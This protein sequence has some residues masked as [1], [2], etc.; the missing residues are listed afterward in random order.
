M[1]DDLRRRYLNDPIFHNMV[2][3][4]RGA[5]RELMLTPSEVREAAVLA[6]V[7]EEER[8]AATW[9][10]MP[11]FKNATC[12]GSYVLGSACGHCERCAWEKERGPYKAV[13][14]MTHEESI[15]Y[16]CR[17]KALVWRSID[18]RSETASDCMCADSPGGPGGFRDEGLALDWMLEA[19]RMRLGDAA[20]VSAL[21][22]VVEHRG[23]ALPP[24]GETNIVRTLGEEGRIIP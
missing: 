24:K 14:K 4:L 7:I 10:E 23:R 15:R 11:Q 9:P 3:V 21:D 1:T 5:I 13:H 12:R 19:V 2:N 20:D 6:C 16:A 22:E 17:I 8:R 18:P